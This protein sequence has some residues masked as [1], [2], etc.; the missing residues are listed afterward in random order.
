MCRQACLY[1]KYRSD[2]RNRHV[3]GIRLIKVLFNLGSE[4]FSVHLTISTTTSNR[5]LLFRTVYS[6]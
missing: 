5:L 3:T 2:Q 4:A 6:T 1:A